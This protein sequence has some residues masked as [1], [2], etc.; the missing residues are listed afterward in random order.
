MSFLRLIFLVFFVSFCGEKKFE[1]N[2]KNDQVQKDNE[3]KTDN[4]V[5]I[6]ESTFDLPACEKNIENKVYFVEEEDILKVCSCNKITNI[7][8]YEIIEITGEK[9]EEGAEGERGTGRSIEKSINVIPEPIL[10][11][12]PSGLDLVLTMTPHGS[13]KIFYT[14]DES[15]PTTQSTVYGPESITIECCD[16]KSYKAFQT[17]WLFEKS[18]IAS[19]NISFL[20]RFDS[21]FGSEGSG[22]GEFLNP[23]DIVIDASDNIYISDNY[24]YDIQKFDPDGNYISTIGSYGSENGQFLNP[25]G[26]AIDEN[27]N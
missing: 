26:M 4:S 13:S 24:R 18:T 5:Y 23:R 15:E 1:K 9:G 3:K 12:T 21:K 20:Y 17:H 25:R 7:C 16:S 27:S 10:S 22:L 11:V 6:V 2:A 14:E 19:Y 8:S